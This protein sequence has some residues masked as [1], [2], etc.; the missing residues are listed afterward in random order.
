MAHTYRAMG[1]YW[2]E[3][4]ETIGEKKKKISQ[5]TTLSTV[6][7]IRNGLVSNMDQFAL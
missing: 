7:P 5:S 2:Q 4:A 1:D 3:I 6:N